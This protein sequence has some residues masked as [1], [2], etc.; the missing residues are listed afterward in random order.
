MMPAIV[1][2]PKRGSSRGT[3]ALSRTTETIP[4]TASQHSTT[5]I[6]GLG[7]RP[8]SALHGVLRTQTKIIKIT[9]TNFCA[10]CH[11]VINVLVFVQSGH[12]NMF[13][14]EFNR[15]RAICWQCFR[16]ATAEISKYIFSS[17]TSGNM[18]I[19]ELLRHP[20]A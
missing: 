15:S 9:R 10:E 19:S 20:V 2:A 16:S 7:T 18:R 1:E 5:T 3:V 11:Q 13:D 4:R 14:N 17:Y 6:D 8:A 12:L